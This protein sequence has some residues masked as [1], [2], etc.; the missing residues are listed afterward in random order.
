MNNV[1]S[2]KHA[3]KDEFVLG[4]S[5]GSITGT[6]IGGGLGL[7]Y[8]YNR[9]SNILMGAVIGAVIGGLISNYFINRK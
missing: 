6:I 5:R 4:Q 7:L 1:K 3:D 2:L 8:A 9:K